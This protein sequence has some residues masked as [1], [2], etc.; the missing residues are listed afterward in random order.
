MPTHPGQNL[1]GAPGAVDADQHL[2]ARASTPEVV[3]QLGQ[4]G[5]DDRDVVGHGIGTGV[6]RAQ[7]HRQWLTGPRRAVVDEGPQRVKAKPLV[8]GGSLSLL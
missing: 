3:G 6:A 4:G 7:Q 8:G 5:L 1:V 2:G